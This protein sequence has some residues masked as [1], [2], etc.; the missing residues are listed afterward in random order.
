VV[1]NAGETNAVE[2]IKRLTGGEG[3]DVAIEAV[4]SAETFEGCYNCLRPAGR[5]SIVGVFPFEK[6]GVSF[7][8]MLRRNLQIRAGRANMINMGLLMS[9]IK[10]GKLDLTSLVTH[11]MPLTEAVEAYRLFGS[12]TGNALK[13]LLHS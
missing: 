11:K 9:L 13:I 4:G 7:R 3:A 1:I 12:R 5:V 2:E 10:G 6:V 8:D